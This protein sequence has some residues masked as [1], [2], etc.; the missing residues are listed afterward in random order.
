MIHGEYAWSAGGRSGREPLV[1][2]GSVDWPTVLVIPPLFEEANRMRHVLVATMRT[3]ADEAIAS[4]LPDLPGTGD[5]GVAT[6]D[7][8]LDDWQAAVSA[9][10][11]TLPAPRL[12]VAIRGG[13]LLDDHAGADARWRLAPE[14]GAR[15]VRDLVRATALSS[16]RP[17]AAIQAMARAEPSRLAGNLLH[18][19][20]FRALELAEPDTGAD[21]RTA[22]LD[23]RGDVQLAGTPVWRRAEPGDDDLLVAAMADDISNWVRRC[24]AR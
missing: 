18:P 11:S 4:V 6:I 16:G 8:R 10:A 7:A 9:A 22:R 1:R 19:A 24:V 23:D 15:V 5:S 17:E 14:S 13:A 12:T 21:V 2:F 20:L 3:L